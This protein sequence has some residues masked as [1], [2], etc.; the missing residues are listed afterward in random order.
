MATYMCHIYM[1]HVRAHVGRHCNVHVS[2][3]VYWPNALGARCVHRPHRWGRMHASW[4]NSGLHVQAAAI[5]SVMGDTETAL[6]TLGRALVLEPNNPAVLL[7]DTQTRIQLAAVYT[8]LGASAL[9]AESLRLGAAAATR[10]VHANGTLEATWKSL[11]DCR[12]RQAQLPAA[13]QPPIA[14]V[15]AGKLESASGGPASVLLAAHGGRVDAARAAQRAYAAA[16]HLNPMRPASWS[17]L[18]LTQ[19]QIAALSAEHPA[20]HNGTVAAASRV[21]AERVLLAALRLA[22]DVAGLWSALGSVHS[23]AAKREYALR[24]AVQLDPADATT[25]LK[26]GRLYHANNLPGKVTVWLQARLCG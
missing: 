1:C 17:D 10:A 5:S 18:A 3:H 8:S 19:H 6:V 24:R 16:V 26:L 21:T 13:A 23:T 4:V 2:L 20:A 12:V 11:G 7:C 25:W 9:A 15:L 22:P 14:D